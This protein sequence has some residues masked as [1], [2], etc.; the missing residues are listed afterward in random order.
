M[1]GR[2]ASERFGAV[3]EDYDRYRPTY[4]EVAMDF[5]TQRL[6]SPQQ[7]RI[8]DIG[9]GTG[10]SSA[11]MLERGYTVYAVEPNANMRAAAEKKFQSNPHFHSVAGG[12]EDTTLPGASVHAVIAAQAFHWFDK[13]RAQREFARILT[14]GGQVAL[15]F[16]ERLTEENAFLRGFEDALLKHSIDYT[17]VNH[18]NLKPEVFENF[19]HAFTRT[20]F[21]HEQVVNLEG[22]LGRVRSCSYV[23]HPGDEGWPALEEEMVALFNAHHCAGRVT[24]LYETQ[25]YLGTL[26][27]QM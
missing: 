5:L 14:P 10:I 13:P 15:L 7:T 2:A 9:S 19:Y 1:S 21:R 16:N 6:G 4:P 25:V 12:A 24:I 22:M 20:C 23:P 3:V 27:I 8:A 17:Q 11:P 26:P 18:A